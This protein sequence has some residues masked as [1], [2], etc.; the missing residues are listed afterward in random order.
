M[1]STLKVLYGTPNQAINLGASINSLANA[2]ALQSDAIDNTT[3][4]FRDVLVQIK[5]K[6][7]ASA[8]GA[9]GQILVFAYGTAD[10]GT[11]YGDTVTG[12]AG[13]LTLTS[14]TN[15]RLV[16]ALNA[17]V[18][19]TVYTSA[20]FSIAVAFGGTLPDHWGI[21]IIN[22]TGAALDGSAGGS[23]WFQGVQD[24]LV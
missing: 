21:V 6:T 14:P 4:L 5:V 23:A 19:A 7:G 16:Q 12:T 18:V 1:A 10:S 22:T 17:N 11:D 15:L 20:P 3:D 24:Q 9:V 8:V 13:L 2:A